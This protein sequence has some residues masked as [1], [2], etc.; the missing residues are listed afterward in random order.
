M[1]ISIKY[2]LLLGVIVAAF[3]FLLGLLGLHTNQ[4]A[5]FGFVIVAII[6]NLVIVVLAVRRLAST[7]TWVQQLVNG[8][9]LGTVAAVIVFLSSWLMTAIVIPDYYAEFAEAARVRAVAGGLTA[10]E[11]EAAVAM[12]TGTSVGSAFQGALGTV[13]TSVVVAGIAGMF[14]RTGRS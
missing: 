14:N 13:I 4:M 8:L 11:I 1:T 5:P 2:G 12:A 7:S 6:V 10:D 9:V 3:G